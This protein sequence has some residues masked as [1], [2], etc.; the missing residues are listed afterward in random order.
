MLNQFL[1]SELCISFSCDNKGWPCPAHQV[2]ASFIGKD[3]CGPM[4]AWLEV[5]KPMVGAVYILVIVVL[6]EKIVVYIS[7]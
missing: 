2:S 3:H 7:G 6:E 5:L 4:I 1:T